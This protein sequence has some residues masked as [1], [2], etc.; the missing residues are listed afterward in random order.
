[1]NLDV[2]RAY[3][4]LLLQT[5]LNLQPGQKLDIGWEL[6]ARDFVDLVTEEAYRL[7]AA[8]VN[9]R[10]NTPSV[11][12]RRAL[13]STPQHLDFVPGWMKNY[14]D[15]IVRDDWAVL[16]L[17]STEDP[18]V[19]EGVPPATLGR[20]QA[21]I[22]GPRDAYRQAQMKSQFCWNVAAYPT[23]GWARQVLGAGASA[24]DLWAVLVPILG[25][26][27]ADP[28]ASWKARIGT[29]NLRGS[30]LNDLKVDR[31]HF[32]GPGTDLTVGL[33]PASR[34]R[35]GDEQAGNG[36]RFAP[37]LPTEEVFTTPDWRRTEGTV[38]CTRPVEVMGAGV[39]GAR[40]TFRE[41]RV[42]DFDAAKNRDVLAQYLA[43]DAQAN[44]LGE[45]ALVDGSSRIFQSGRVFH[46]ILFDENAAC[47]IALGAG[48]PDAVD[49]G[50]DAD[51]G[52][53]LAQGCNISQVHTDFM[54]GGPGI[55][56]DLVT[57]DGRT[58]RAL[59]RGTF[60]L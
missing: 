54:I 33:M 58:V 49:G 16:A 57:A 19:M 27:E 44:V 35:G 48:Y 34:W 12:R 9:P 46:N 37:N 41:G 43:Q 32:T 47:H 55:N 1:M 15:E 40:F 28:K 52:A 3:A 5:G 2:Q 22:A 10:L 36:R 7:G 4:R 20:I 21:A 11:T 45:V 56:V 8:Y 30:L 13:H 14:W 25:L 17:Y 6:P 38:V 31:V 18:D 60:V 26:D 50:R 23:D 24:D 53:L 29:L 51:S 59:D 39:E 42:V